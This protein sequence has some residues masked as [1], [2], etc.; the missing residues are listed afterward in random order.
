MT[1]VLIAAAAVL[2]ALAVFL[3][4]WSIVVN[5]ASARYRR[6]DV[7]DIAYDW[8]KRRASHLRRR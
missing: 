7:L 3:V 8:A 5:H 1:V 2:A 6:K 4:V